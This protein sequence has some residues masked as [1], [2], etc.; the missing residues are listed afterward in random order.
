MKFKEPQVPLKIET[1]KKII[2][3]SETER[4]ERCI[5]NHELNAKLQLESMKIGNIEFLTDGEAQATAVMALE[6]LPSC[7]GKPTLHEIAI[8]TR[9]ASAHHRSMSMRTSAFPRMRSRPCACKGP[10]RVPAEQAFK[11]D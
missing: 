1:A 10:L 5:Q 9:I 3:T 7:K 2:E 11:S 4:L 8:M 6:S